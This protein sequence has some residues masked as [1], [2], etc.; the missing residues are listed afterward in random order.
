MFILRADGTVNS[1]RRPARL[2]RPRR[3]RVAGAAAGRRADRAEPARLRDLGPRPGAQPEGL[4]ADLLRVRHRH[5]RDPVAPTTDGRLAMLSAD[6]TTPLAAPQT[7]YETT[8]TRP[9]FGLTDLLT[10]LGERQAAR[11]AAVTVGGG[12]RLARRRAAAAA[13]VHRA[14]DAAAAGSQQ[15]SGSAAALAALGAL[16]GLAGGLAAED[17]RRAVR[18]AAEERQ[19]A[20]RARRALRPAGSTTTSRPTRRCARCCR[21]YIRVVADKKSGVIGRRGRRRGPEVRRRPRQRARE[22]R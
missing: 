8:T 9:T 4:R 13:D 12:G 20:A 15:Q 10:W 6:S 3:P 18:R 2:L 14:D 22:P 11:S 19:R 7:L 5:R 1:A 16:G 17:A 21:G